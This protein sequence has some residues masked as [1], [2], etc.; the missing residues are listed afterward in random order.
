MRKSIAPSVQTTQHRRLNRGEKN[1]AF[2]FIEFIDLKGN[3]VHV[4][5]DAVYIVREVIKTA[6]GQSKVVRGTRQEGEPV[7]EGSYCSLIC[8]RGVG[9][10]VD[11][12]IDQVLE[13]LGRS[14][15]KERSERS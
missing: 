8:A 9:I 6:P 7:A 3:P 1:M 10:D 5:D 2:T 13:A 14:Q 4:R 15:K 11:A 12:S